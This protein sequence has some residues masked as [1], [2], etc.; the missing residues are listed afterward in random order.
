MILDFIQGYMIGNGVVGESKYDVS[1]VVAF[2]HGMG[3]ISNDLYKVRVK[4]KTYSLK[5]TSF[6]GNITATDIQ[7]SVYK[8]STEQ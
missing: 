6:K 1:S 5:I 8:T 4:R 3:L 2:A 7:I